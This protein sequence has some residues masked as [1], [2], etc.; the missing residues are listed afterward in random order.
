MLVLNLLGVNIFWGT[1]FVGVKQKWGVNKCSGSQFFGGQHFW[2]VK[3]WWGPNLLG[4]QILGSNILSGANFLSCQK[5]LGVKRGVR[6]RV[7]ACS[8]TGSEDPPWRAPVFQTFPIPTADWSKLWPNIDR[9][10]SRQVVSTQQLRQS[11]KPLQLD[12]IVVCSRDIKL[13]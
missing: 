2:G 10:S 4:V 8:D 1:T 12:N 6:F 7:L 9:F 3:K 5:M 13:V 11:E